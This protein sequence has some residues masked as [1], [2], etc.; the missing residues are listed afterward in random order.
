MWDWSA[1]F[2][3]R[4]TWSTPEVPSYGPEAHPGSGYTPWTALPLLQHVM[5]LLLYVVGR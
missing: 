5:D 4:G 3:S 1:N 2:M